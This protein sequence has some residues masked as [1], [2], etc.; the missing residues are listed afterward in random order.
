MKEYEERMAVVKELI[1]K[2]KTGCRHLSRNHGSPARIELTPE[3][4]DDVYEQFTNLGIEVVGESPD[5][6]K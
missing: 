4:I 3:Q 2:G 5:G 1:D 6:A